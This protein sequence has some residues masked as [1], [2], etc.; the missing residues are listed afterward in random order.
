MDMNNR[1]AIN[2]RATY[3]HLLLDKGAD[4]NYFGGNLQENSLQ[5]AV[6]GRGHGSLV[7]DLIRRGANTGHKSNLG[8]DSLQIAVRCGNMNIAYILLQNNAKVSPNIYHVKF[9]YGYIH[10][11]FM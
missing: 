8:M 7:L 11:L 2:N 5:W 4:I 6:R 9:L 1:A 10:L 3:I